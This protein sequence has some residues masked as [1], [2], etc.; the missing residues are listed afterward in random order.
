MWVCRLAGSAAVPGQGWQSL[1][2]RLSAL[3]A[4][5]QNRGCS[6]LRLL[7]LPE[8]RWKQRGTSVPGTALGC[9]HVCSRSAQPGLGSGVRACQP[10]LMKNDSKSTG[11][12]HYA[13][14]ISYIFVE[15]PYAKLDFSIKLHAVPRLTLSAVTGCVVFLGYL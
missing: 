8:I 10:V 13:I 3:E 12:H 4:G 5:L 9:V 6:S 11:Q 15:S 2:P 14:Y 7:L 1:Q